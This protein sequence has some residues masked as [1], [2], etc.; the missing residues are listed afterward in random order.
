MEALIR[1]FN[2]TVDDISAQLEV[3]KKAEKDLVEAEI[4]GETDHIIITNRGYY[5]QEVGEA[6][7]DLGYKIRCIAHKRTRQ[8]NQIERSTRL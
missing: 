2:E 7:C 3:L 5:L 6:L 1:E 8:E 4:E